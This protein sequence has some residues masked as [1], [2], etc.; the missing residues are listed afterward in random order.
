[1]TCSIYGYTTVSYYYD[2]LDRVRTVKYNYVERYSYDYCTSGALS[3]VK[4]HDTGIEIY[5]QYDSIGRL[6]A[7]RSYDGDTLLDAVYY[8]YDSYGRASVVRSK[9][10]G[11]LTRRRIPTTTI[12]VPSTPSAINTTSGARPTPISSPTL[13]PTAEKSSTVR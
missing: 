13:T 12:T 7:Q 4:E 1:M 3:H 2:Y 6:I 10:N 5:Y 11:D 8:T 9:A